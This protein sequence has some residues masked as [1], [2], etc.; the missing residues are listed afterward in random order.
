MIRWCAEEDY[1]AGIP[2]LR[3]SQPAH[4]LTKA[5]SDLHRETTLNFTTPTTPSHHVPPA[6]RHTQQ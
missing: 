3:G 5:S 1:Q 4:D 2:T 6:Q